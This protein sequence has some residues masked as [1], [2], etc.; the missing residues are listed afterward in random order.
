MYHRAGIRYYPKLQSCV[1]FTPVTG[2]RLLTKSGPQA[3]AVRRA[4][5]STLVRIAGDT[6]LTT[7]LTWCLGMCVLYMCCISSNCVSLCMPVNT[8][9]Y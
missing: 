3:A 2:Q 6:A 4:L 7:V 5:A 8:H 9:R 1:P